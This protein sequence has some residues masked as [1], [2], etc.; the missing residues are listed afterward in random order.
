MAVFLGFWPQLVYAGDSPRW[1]PAGLTRPF[2]ASRSTVK[3]NMIIA[4]QTKWLLAV[5]ILCGGLLAASAP[6]DDSPAA[7]PADDQPESIGL[8]EAVDQNLIEAKFIARSSAKGRLV[9]TN[10]TNQPISVQL[11]EVFAGVPALRQFGGGGGGRG[12]GGGGLG[13]G[14]GGGQSVGGGGGGRGGG[15]RGGGGGRFNIAP[16][17]IGRIDVPLLCLEHG[18][19]EPSSSK[20]YDIHPIEDVVDS[21]AVIEIV[22]AY[23]NG[24]LPRGGAQAAVW[25]LNSNVSWQEL[26][27]KLTGTVRNYNREPYF[28]S[29]E[30]QAAMAIA[31]R[32][33]TLTAGKK[34]QRSSQTDDAEAPSSESEDNERYEFEKVEPK[35]EEET[36]AETAVD[37][38][39]GG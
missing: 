39:L 34:V 25:H 8:F 20:P 14:G 31:N 19:R 28:S 12:G 37:S 22:K 29:G 18:L 36:E 17:K 5:G 35:A 16:E 11:P 3:L 32:A 4:Q 9:L 10:K 27:A 30:M 38:D 6:A 15:G 13:G 26:A 33:L 24:E 2:Y 1:A 21:L 23:A 7:A